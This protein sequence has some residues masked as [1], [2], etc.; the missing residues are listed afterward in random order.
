MEEY[1]ERATVVYWSFRGSIP[2]SLFLFYPMSFF[3]MT[4]IWDAALMDGFF[5][6]GRVVVAVV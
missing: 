3:Y 5:F 4:R 1:L 6:C 2:R